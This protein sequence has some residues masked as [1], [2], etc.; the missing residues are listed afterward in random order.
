MADTPNVA[1][2][3]D[4]TNTAIAA[5]VDVIARGTTPDMLEAQRIL[6]ERIAL[7][8]DIVP[9]R[10]PAPR[11]ITEIGGYL[12]LLEAM[13][14]GDVE[15]ELIASALG[16]AGAGY[17]PAAFAEI[18][19]LAF[20]RVGNDRP[21]GPAQAAI[22]LAITLRADFAD[23]FVAARDAIHAQGCMLPLLAP[24]ARTL[25]ARAPGTAAAFDDLGILG[26]AIDVV[27]AAILT[28]PDSDALALAR[29]QGTTDPFA[30]VARELDG[31]TLVAQAGWDAQKCDATSCTIASGN[32]RYLPLAP[33]LAAA[34]WYPVTPFVAPL[35]AT[36]RGNGG[37]YVNTTGLVAGTTQLGD[38]LALLY[39]RAQI[40][41]SAYAPRL[42]QTWNGTAF[43]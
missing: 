20:V 41:A 6:M 9:S 16:V 35:D 34:G 13:R 33:I 17:A 7:E 27:P 2:V 14:A 26:R 19:P 32:R 23:A 11:N 28:D 4:A 31:G 43:A 21:A 38:E 8:G 42:A 18:P 30:L 1:P 15:S 29:A 5:L 10:V 36:H 25:P 39:T 22:P 24:A 3:L 40:A 12:N 37:R